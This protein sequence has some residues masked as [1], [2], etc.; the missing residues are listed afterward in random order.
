MADDKLLKAL[1]RA[2]ASGLTEQQIKE[3]LVMDGWNSNDVNGAYA[4][5]VLSH[6]PIGSNVMSAWKVQQEESKTSAV[7]HF[8][9]LIGL[10]GL[11]LIAVVVV[12]WYGYTV[13]FMERYTLRNYVEAKIPPTY[14]PPVPKEE[15]VSTTTPTS[16]KL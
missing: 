15:Q 12:D 11:L 10:T 6:K 5:H 16:T 2:V 1:Q 7:G 4:L 13:P 9:R 8:F 14:L 3:K